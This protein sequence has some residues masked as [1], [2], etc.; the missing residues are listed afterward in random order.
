MGEDALAGRGHLWCVGE[1]LAVEDEHIFCVMKVIL[2]VLASGLDVIDAVYRV[3]VTRS[4][5]NHILVDVVGVGADPLILVLDGFAQV[6]DVMASVLDSLLHGLEGHHQ[7]SLDLDTL[8]VVVLVPNGIAI[9]EFIHS[10]VEIAGG[11]LFVSLV[12][13]AVVWLLV[14]IANVEVGLA[15]VVGVLLGGGLGLNF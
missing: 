6:F 1:L 12:R 9:I 10:S 14:V 11:E 7:L 4:S 15:G 5:G 13:R 2:D 3:I 8:F